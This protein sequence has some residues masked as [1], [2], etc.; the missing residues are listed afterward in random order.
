[1][2]R[3]DLW[4]VGQRKGRWL[5]NREGVAVKE[6]F[7]LKLTRAGLAMNK[8]TDPVIVARLEQELERM[9]ADGTVSR[10]TENFLTREDNSDVK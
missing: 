2:G 8:N 7:T 10:I 1:M 3:I 4:P 9:H 5:A 6:I